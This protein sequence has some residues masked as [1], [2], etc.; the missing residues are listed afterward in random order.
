[1]WD[2]QATGIPVPIMTWR[3]NDE[4]LRPGFPSGVAI[5]ANNSLVIRN[6]R[7]EDEGPYQCHAS[8]RLGEHVVQAV[9]VVRG[10]K[11]KLTTGCFVIL[12][13][14]SFKSSI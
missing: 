13:S 8:S 3:K 12:V 9:L 5:L 7:E 6:V 11:N 14:H 10:E 1:M 4:E 2:C